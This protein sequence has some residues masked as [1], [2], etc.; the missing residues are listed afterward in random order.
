M[1]SAATADSFAIDPAQEAGWIRAIA[2]GD[3]NAFVQLYDRFRG[4]IFSTILKVLRNREDAEDTAQE[5][6]A[7]IWDKAHLF[8]D[9]RGRALTWIA[10][11]A[12][13]RAIDRLRKAQRRS[14]LDETYLEREAAEEEVELRD[15]S[16]DAAMAES[17][18]ALRRAMGGLTPD[19]REAIELVYIGGLTQAQASARLGVPLGT[20]KARVRRGLARLRGA[21]A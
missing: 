19:Q 9:E 20:V 11:M 15:A 3:A 4:V 5:V 18:A 14:R 13:N 1:S 8:R 7:Q 12:R 2:R 21:M 6:F 17:V 10:T 16:D